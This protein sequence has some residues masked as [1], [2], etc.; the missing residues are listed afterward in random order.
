MKKTLYFLSVLLISIFTMVSCVEDDLTEQVQNLSAPQELDITFNITQDNSGL[1]TLTPSASGAASYELFYADGTDESIDLLPGEST[2]RMYPEG[3]YPIRLVATAINGKTSELVKDLMVSFRAP[4]NLVIDIQQDPASNLGIIVKATAD[5]ATM[6]EVT[7]GEDPSLPAQPLAVDGETSYLYTN[8]GDYIVTVTAFSG[9]AATTSGTQ[10][11]TIL[12]PFVLPVDFESATLPYNFIDFGGAASAKVA[13]PDTNGNSSA[14]VAETIKTAGAQVF[15]GTVVELDNPIDFT[16]FQKLKID[17]WSPLPAGT[18]V[19]MKLENAADAN[20]NTEIDAATLVSSAWETLVYDF[21]AADLTQE[22]HKI[23]LFYD[24]GNTGNGD[25]F[26]FDNIELTD[27]SAV[28][29]ELPLDFESPVLNYGFTEFGG[30]PTSVIANP[31]MSG[32]NTSPM[33]AN[34]LKVNNAQTFAGAFIDLDNPIDFGTFDKIKMKVWTPQAGQIVKLKIENLSDPN[35][36]IEVDVMTTVANAWEE[37]IFDFPGVMSSNDYQRIVVFFDFGNTGV[38]ADYYFDDLE[39]TNGAPALA[40]PLTFDNAAL[41]YNFTNFGGATSTVI[42]NP[43]ATGANTTAMV[44]NLN[45]SSGSQVWGGSFIELDGPINFSSL[46]KI[47]MKTWSPQS[48]IVVKMK[49]ENL[50]DPNINIEVDVTNTVASVWEELTFDFTGINNA[51]NY[52]R[53]VVF[54]DFGN[55][56]TGADYYFDEIELTN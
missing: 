34:T 46:Q 7:F 16:T 5:F 26:Y 40:L 22:Y 55:A 15:A 42:A 3:N 54:F 39:V 32:I 45:K 47:K 6:F 18:V 48:G 41:T 20:I 13:N 10:T 4:E 53:L 25:T 50:A 17:S 29:L 56:G 8:T 12:D 44:G 2:E 30:A 33:V 51:N 11:V 23:I 19:K 43:D 21:S 36:N 14:F 49:L 1:V 9:G 31:D 52:Q 38:G 37:L 28:A 27:Q 24:F 35:I